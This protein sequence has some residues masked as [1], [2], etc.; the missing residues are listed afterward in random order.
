MG[1][2]GVGEE[3][4]VPSERIGEGSGLKFDACAEPV[5]GFDV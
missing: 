3:P 1:V 4:Y 5:E 2:K